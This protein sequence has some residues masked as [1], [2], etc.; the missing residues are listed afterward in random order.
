MSDVHIAHC[1][2]VARSVVKRHRVTAP[3]VDVHAIARAVGVTVND[4]DLGSVDARLYRRDGDWI[5]EVNPGFAPTAQRFSV[6]HELGHL[7]LGHEGCGTNADDE[8][9]ANVFAAELLMP[10]E[11]VKAALRTTTRLG[12]L[13]SLFQVS[14][15]AM[16]IKLDEQRLMLKLSSFD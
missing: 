14:K 9:A 6:A 4:A 1:R 16:Q 15:Q 11:L 13:A 12:E 5:L 3:P 2:Q 10:L 8:R 7:L